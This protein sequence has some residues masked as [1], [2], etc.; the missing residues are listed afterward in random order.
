MRL[1]DL[2]RAQWRISA[3]STGANTCVQ[4]AAVD[5]VVVVQNSNHPHPAGTALAVPAQEWERF[6]A[7]AVAGR[8][9][10]A[11]LTAPAA[12]G[13]FHLNATP[14]GGVELRAADSG[15]VAFTSAEWDVFTT[16][17]AAGEFTLPWLT[18]PQL[19]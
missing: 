1:P 7:E 13:P 2:A 5:D 6:L 12:L 4:A 19:N 18:T 16:G 8:A 14:D 9:N 3:H 11:A 10:R 17:V 15:P